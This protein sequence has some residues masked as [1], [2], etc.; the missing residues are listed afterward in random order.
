MTNGGRRMSV[1]KRSA[2][3]SA[4]FVVLPLFVG[5]AIPFGGGVVA[6]L[7]GALAIIVAVACATSRG[8][9]VLTLSLMAIAVMTASWN[10]VRVAGV[11]TVSDVFLVC[12]AAFVFAYRALE[13]RAST[14]RYY[15]PFLLASGLIG[16]G[17]LI[18]TLIG[19]YG[20]H[21]IPDLVRF[22][23]STFV[24]LFV[25]SV[26]SPPEA[27]VRLLLWAY[28]YGAAA[29]ALLGI[30]SFNDASGRA[31]GLSG[32]SN[33]LAISC[34][35]GLGVGVGFALSSDG[36]GRRVAIAL[37]G[38]VTVGVIA[39]GSRAAVVGVVAYLVGFVLYSRQWRLLWLSAFAGVTLAV[40]VVSGLV[41]LS[42]SDAIGRLSGSDPTAALSDDARSAARSTALDTIEARPITGVGFSA[43]KAAHNVYLQLWAA[44]GIFGVAGALGLLLGL[45]R[46]V[47]SRPR[48]DM[49]L[50][51]LVCA[52][53][54]YLAAAAF[55]TVLW[56][57]YLWLHVAL[58]LALCSARNRPMTPSRKARN[59]PWPALPEDRDFA[60]GLRPL[61]DGV[62]KES[63][64]GVPPKY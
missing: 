24:L 20:W 21:G 44:S 4:L 57:R 19:G 59:V 5:F 11:F 36:S 13:P 25:F 49:L 58:A 27:S 56:E 12:A 3:A 34:L 16:F 40:L 51:S 14:W 64:L 63:L 47:R 18:G 42:S 54:G 32:H 6:A 48:K 7:V 50:G 9:R 39:S 33:H 38:V 22:G 29:N 15:G 55:S 23:L 46:M 45:A 60:R 17:G 53:G 62:A 26:W 30:V 10:G 35:L 37:A 2:L 1:A 52:Y 8:T 28:L 43:A 41:Q 31:I 61:G